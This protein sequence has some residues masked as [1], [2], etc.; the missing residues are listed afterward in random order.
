[1]NCM[2]RVRYFSTCDNN[3]QIASSQCSFHRRR[4]RFFERRDLFF[5]V[6]EMKH[7]ENL[8]FF[9]NFLGDKKFLLI[10]FQMGFSPGFFVIKFFLYLG[11][12]TSFF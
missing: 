6:I 5:G 2:F 10:F 4:H 12:S 1:M 7:C 8:H 9:D 11:H 3:P